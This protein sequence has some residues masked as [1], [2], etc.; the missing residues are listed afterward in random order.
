MYYIYLFHVNEATDVRSSF[1]WIA[2]VG[3]QHCTLKGAPI[4]IGRCSANL[5]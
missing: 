3:L 1:G 4:G 5:V 2:N